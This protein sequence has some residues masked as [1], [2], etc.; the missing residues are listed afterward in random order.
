MPKVT[1]FDRN[2]MM[3][4]SYDDL[5]GP[6]SP[7]RVIEAFVS[8]L[9][10]QALGAKKEAAAGRPSYDKKALLK[11]YLYGYVHEICSSRK[12]A[13]SCCTNIEV[14]WMIGGIKPDFRTISDFRKNNAELLKKVFCEFNRRLSGLKQWEYASSDGIKMQ[15]LNTDDSIFTLCTPEDRLILLNAHAA[16][17][18]DEQTRDNIPTKEMLEA[19]LDEARNVAAVYEKYLKKMDE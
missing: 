7:A 17:Y 11:L 1:G 2:Q 4:C 19:K 18:L 5:I 9:D 12:L 6:K 10:L 8:N 14:Q 15:P 3:T 13:S 16:D